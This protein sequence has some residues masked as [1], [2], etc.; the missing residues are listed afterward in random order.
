MSCHEVIDTFF[1]LFAMATEENTRALAVEAM[2]VTNSEILGL[3]TNREL[4]RY[5][6]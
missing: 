4:L 6:G 1:D 5:F 2:A 3:L